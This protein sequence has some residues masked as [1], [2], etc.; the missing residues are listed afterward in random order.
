[1]ETNAIPEYKKDPD[2]GSH[3]SH[4]AGRL[5]DSPFT[6]PDYQEVGLSEELD[7]DIIRECKGNQGD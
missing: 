7:A 4:L 3:M 1:M 6:D 2:D 5:N